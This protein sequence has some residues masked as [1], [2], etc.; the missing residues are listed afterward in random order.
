MLGGPEPY[1]SI[2][3]PTEIVW[4][5]KDLIIDISALPVWNDAIEGSRVTV[6]PEAGHSTMVEKPAE[7]AAVVERLV[8][9]IGD[10]D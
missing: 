5:A 2:R 10:D 1:H 3:C 7:V 6:V 4:G 8:D 9:R